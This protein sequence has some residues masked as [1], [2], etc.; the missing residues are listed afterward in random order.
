MVPTHKRNV[1]HPSPYTTS[2][3]LVLQANLAALV[4]L[5]ESPGSFQLPTAREITHETPRGSLGQTSRCHEAVRRA[6]VPQ[7]GAVPQKAEEQ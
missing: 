2:A 7:K 6:V 1:K 3:S 4:A 5:L